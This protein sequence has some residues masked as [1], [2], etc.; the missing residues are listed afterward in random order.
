MSE[1]TEDECKAEL[2]LLLAHIT[3]M[4]VILGVNTGLDNNECFAVTTG[5]RSSMNLF[6]DLSVLMT[7][8]VVFEIA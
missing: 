4:L 1:V 5:C 6:C 7:P 3:A 2:C 8:L